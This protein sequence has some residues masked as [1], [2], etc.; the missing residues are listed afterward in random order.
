VPCGRDLRVAVGLASSLETT[1]N[2]SFPDGE[3]ASP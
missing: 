2:P 1:T 3:S